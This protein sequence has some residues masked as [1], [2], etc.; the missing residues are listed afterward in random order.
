MADLSLCRKSCR[1]SRTW[2]Y[3]HGGAGENER[4]MPPIIR[5]KL[6]AINIDETEE[7]EDNTDC[8]FLRPS[9]QRFVCKVNSGALGGGDSV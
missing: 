9:Q 6:K 4:R 5:Q 7:E 8:S 1:G 2:N 3:I